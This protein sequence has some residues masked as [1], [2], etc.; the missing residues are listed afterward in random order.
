MSTLPWS[1]AGAELAKCAL[2]GMRQA[3]ALPPLAL[4]HPALD[5]LLAAAAGATTGADLCRRAGLLALLL[6]A[7]APPPPLTAMA[8]P[9][10]P[11]EHGLPLSA[12]GVAVLEHAFN[13]G[14]LEALIALLDEVQTAG[15]HLPAEFLVRLPGFSPQH[16][17]RARLRALGSPTLLWLAQQH[18][19]WRWLLESAVAPS[20]PPPDFDLASGPARV[21]A[22]AALRA[23]DPAGARA[24]LIAAWPACAPEERAAL[25]PALASGLGPADEPW[26]ESVLEDRR[27]EVRGHARALLLA[28]PDSGLRQR[29]LARLAPLFNVR[30]D[31]KLE[32]ALPA[33]HDKA[34]GRDGIEPKPPPGT[35]ERSWWLAQ[36]LGQV[37]LDQLALQLALPPAQLLEALQTHADRQTLL[38]ALASGWAAGQ[39]PAVDA[40]WAGV[41]TSGRSIAHLLL[42]SDAV[43][44][45][46]AHP[47]LRPQLLDLLTKGEEKLLALVLP[48]LPAA[49]PQRWERALSQAML[50]ASQRIQD[51]GHA[52]AIAVTESV[53]PLAILRIPADA[54][55]L[56]GWAALPAQGLFRRDQTVVENRLYWRRALAAQLSTH[57]LP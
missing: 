15:R 16:R 10:L 14:D 25:L 51:S 5:A 39:D 12:A 40:V 54:D 48:A 19:D 8:P 2:L 55:L 29:A 22:L 57:P 45:Q 17:W 27:K 38:P 28:L 23:N 34:M 37:R 30:P 46:L 53:L 41:L 26:L 47:A 36:L 43:V 24:Q 9:P 33:A 4:G 18:P 20:E 32:I 42:Q 3:G 35:G 11:T 13:Q 1:A 7:A 52:R 56:E 6:A 49:L 44:A 21:R 50:Q 31:G